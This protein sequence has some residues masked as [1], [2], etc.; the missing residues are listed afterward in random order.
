M[1]PLTRLPEKV[2]LNILSNIS[3]GNAFLHVGPV[4]RSMV[5]ANHWLRSI[6]T[7][8]FLWLALAMLRA[9]QARLLLQIDPSHVAAILDLKRGC[10]GINI[11]IKINYA[12]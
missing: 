10:Q 8:M 7:Y 12:F 11:V 3:K 4:T 6:E 1:P 2:A 5:G 9:T